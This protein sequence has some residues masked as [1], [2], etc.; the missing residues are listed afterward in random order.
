MNTLAW[1][2]LMSVTLGVAEDKKSQQTKIQNADEGQTVDIQPDAELLLFLA[3]WN[4]QKAL[5]FHWVQ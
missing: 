2:L 4:E 1:M 5:K 3:E